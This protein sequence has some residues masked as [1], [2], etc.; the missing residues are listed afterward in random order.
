MTFEARGLQK[1]LQGRT[2][3]TDLAF[4]V[5]V[6]QTLAV[7]GASGSGK[8]QLLRQLAGLDADAELTQA[9]SITYLDRDLDEWGPFQWRTEVCF[10]PQHAPRLSGTPA[11]F[12]TRIAGFHEQQTR[13]ASDPKQWAARFGLSDSHWDQPWT[14]LSIGE[15]Q[16]MLLANLLSRRP[17]VL[18][19]DEPTAAL[20]VD[21]V[22]AVEEALADQTCIWVT[23]SPEQAERVASG[24][25]FLSKESD[26][27]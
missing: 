16:R 8:S 1:E 2:L 10:V 26:A 13:N 3:Y 5:E 14:E 24:S 11:E 20:D 18:L 15:R 22:R 19:L 17:G 7:R 6:G 4:R 9:G 21:S 25:L 27:D 12:A 23:H